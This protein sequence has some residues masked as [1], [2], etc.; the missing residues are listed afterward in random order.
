MILSDFHKGQSVIRDFV[1]PQMLVYK[2]STRR[3]VR[4]KS[5]DFGLLSDDEVRKMSV[6]EVSNLS[7]YHRGVPQADAVNDIRMGEFVCPSLWLSAP[8]TL[9]RAAFFRRHHR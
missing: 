1:T 9:T 3:A 5:I 8:V 7:I 6:V 4:T 2:F